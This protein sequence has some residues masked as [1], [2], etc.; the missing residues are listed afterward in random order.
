MGETNYLV[1]R[2]LTADI[3]KSVVAKES[4]VNYVNLARLSCHPLV[5]VNTVQY[6]KIISPVNFSFGVRLPPDPPDDARRPVAC[7][8]KQY[9]TLTTKN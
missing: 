9:I 3:D 4:L 2:K 8:K 6:I 5:C 7:T 1:L